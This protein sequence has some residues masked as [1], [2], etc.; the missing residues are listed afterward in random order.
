MAYFNLGQDVANTRERKK[1][2]GQKVA[3]YY[4]L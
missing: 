2:A 1:T 3:K 4:L